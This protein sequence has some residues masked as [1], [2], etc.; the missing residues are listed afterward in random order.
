MLVYLLKFPNNKCYIGATTQE[1]D[2]RIKQHKFAANSGY[3]YPVHSAIR[4]HKDF[5]VKVLSKANNVEDLETLEKKAIEEFR[6]K[7]DCYNVKDGGFQKTGTQGLSISQKRKLYFKNRVNR[8]RASIERGGKPFKMYSILDSKIIGEWTSKG[9][10]SQ[11]LGINRKGI[12]NALNGS[13]KH[14]NGFIP[15]YLDAI[16]DLPNLISAAPKAFTVINNS[17]NSKSI[18]FNISECSRKLDIAR[19]TIKSILLGNTKGIV[20]DSY[21]YTMYYNKVEL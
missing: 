9:L 12:D 11:D 20:A 10:C 3:D 5:E 8:D 21:K 18:W 19:S 14:V 4:K 13:S 17:D 2:K 7:F 16:S 1:L 6:N 15:C